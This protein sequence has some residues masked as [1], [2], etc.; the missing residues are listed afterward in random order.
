M[1]QQLPEIVTNLPVALF[2]LCSLKNSAA[3]IYPV[4]LILLVIYTT[5]EILFLVEK[6]SEFKF[7]SKTNLQMFV[8][9]VRHSSH[10]R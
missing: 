6:F 4:L 5:K 3:Q 1:L 8:K 7:L 9:I 10:Q 2:H